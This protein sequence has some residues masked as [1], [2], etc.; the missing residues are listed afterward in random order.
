[1]TKRKKS[2]LIESDIK[3]D[4]DNETLPDDIFS[5]IDGL[6]NEGVPFWIYKQLPDGKEAFIDKVFPPYSIE[7]LKENYG[8]GAFMI[9]VREGAKVTHRRKVIIAGPEKNTIQK[10]ESISEIKSEN[11]SGLDSIV[12][13]I[14]AV[15]AINENKQ[16]GIETF[17]SMIQLNMQSMQ[18]MNTMMIT[19][20]NQQVEMMKNNNENKTGASM[21]DTINKAIEELG[22]IGAAYLD[23]KNQSSGNGDNKKATKAVSQNQKVNISALIKILNKFQEQKIGYDDFIKVIKQYFMSYLPMFKSMNYE[24]IINMGKQYG[25]KI[26]DETY[27]KGLFDVISKL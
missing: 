27:L 22:N 13:V 9:Y 2:E 23:N 16:T 19:M 15:N 8:G 26:L 24:M 3:N 6:N 11:I 21:Y 1:M 12:S 4:N 5:E 10:S 20:M 25:L 7:L 18:A 14:K 17:Q